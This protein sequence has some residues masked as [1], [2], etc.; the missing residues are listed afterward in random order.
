MLAAR[1][2]QIAVIQLLEAVEAILQPAK[3]LLGRA[4][5]LL[6]AGLVPILG[7]EDEGEVV[8]RDGPVGV[9]QHEQVGSTYGKLGAPGAAILKDLALNH[10]RHVTGRPT[11]SGVPLTLLG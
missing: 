2:D 1:Q 6:L 3:P 8:K 11:I 10:G 7:T 5:E 9:A 4:L